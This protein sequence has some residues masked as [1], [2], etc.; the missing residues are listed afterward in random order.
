MLTSLFRISK[1]PKEQMDALFWRIII[2]T[3]TMDTDLEAEKIDRN[4]EEKELSD[5]AKDDSK[6]SIFTMVLPM[7]TLKNEDSKNKPIEPENYKFLENL[8][9]YITKGNT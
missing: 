2:G 7:K 3:Y 8:T 1:I 6:D 9:N 5:E 4:N